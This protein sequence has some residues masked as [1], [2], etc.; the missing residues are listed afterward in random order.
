[1]STAAWLIIAGAAILLNIVGLLAAEAHALR[2]RER[3][4]WE[5]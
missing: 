2:R 3:D 5:R 1:M 4:R